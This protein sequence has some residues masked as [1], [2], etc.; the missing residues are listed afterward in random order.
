MESNGETT[1]RSLGSKP[2]W[3]FLT[4][5]AHALVCISQNP[6]VRL[7]EVASKVGIGERAAHR[8]VHDLIDAGYVSHTKVGRRNVYQ[9]SLEQPLRHPLEAHHQLVEVFGPLST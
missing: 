7:A 9:L 8:I 1:T 6:E 5:H 4:N 3:T 2:S